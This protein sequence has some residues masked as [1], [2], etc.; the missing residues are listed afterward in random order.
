MSHG[1]YQGQRRGGWKKQWRPRYEPDYGT[2]PE[3]PAPPAPKRPSIRGTPDLWQTLQTITDPN[4]NATKT[5][6]AMR[7]PGGLLV[8]TCTRGANYA[9]EAL[10]V[11]PGAELLKTN[12]GWAIV[13]KAR[14]V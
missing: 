13:E 12:E 9:A 6:R 3:P 7:V 2:P 1:T 10:A 8:N 5:T 14:T 11:V 4:S